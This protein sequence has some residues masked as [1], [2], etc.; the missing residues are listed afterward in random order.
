MTDVHNDVLEEEDFDTILSSDIEFTGSLTFDKPFL[1]R[2]KLSG[3]ITAQSVLVIDE[4]AAV[5]AGIKASR[6]VIR[7]TVKGDVT[8]SE[9]VEISVTGRLNGNI[10]TPEISLESGCVFNGRCTMPDKKPAL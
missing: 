7:G 3:D 10:V 1:I 8:A 6:V 9:K 2:G 5:E 4:G